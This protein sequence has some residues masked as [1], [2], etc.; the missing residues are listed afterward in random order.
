V[1]IPLKLDPRKNIFFLLQG[2]GNLPLKQKF[3]METD[4]ADLH[5]LLYGVWAFFKFYFMQIY[6]VD[7]IKYITYQSEFSVLSN[8]LVYSAKHFGSN[9]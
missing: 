2:E 1:F 3:F 9:F 5:S 8:T 7:T 4:G 6:T